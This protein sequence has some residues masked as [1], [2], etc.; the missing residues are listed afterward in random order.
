MNRRSVKPAVTGDAR[1]QRAQLREKL[2]YAAHRTLEALWAMRG[3]DG[4]VTV[5]IDKLATAR[6]FAA[7]TPRQV[8][9]AL[10]RLRRAGLV[11]D[12]GVDKDPARRRRHLRRRRVYGAPVAGVL[13]AES[14]VLVP[15]ATARWLA[16]ACAHGG[17][18]RGAGRPPREGR[19]KL[20]ASFSSG[21]VEAP[22]APDSSAS[23]RG[24]S[25]GNDSEKP[26][27]P[28]QGNV[29]IKLAAS[30]S[31]SWAKTHTCG[32]LHISMIW[33]HPS[34]LHPGKNPG[35]GRAGA[36]GS[37]SLL[38]SERGGAGCAEAL[39]ALGGPQAAPADPG[40]ASVGPDDLR[41]QGGPAAAPPDRGMFDPIRG[42][43]GNPWQTAG[44]VTVPGPP[45]LPAEASD[46]EC[47]HALVRA[48]G[49]AV[50]A[51]L[52]LKVFTGRPMTPKRKEW[53]ML[54]TAAA[55][56]REANAAPAAWAA[57]SCDVWKEYGNGGAPPLQWVFSPKR[58]DERRG[59]FEAE[60][61]GYGGGT[62]VNG[63]AKRALLARYL[64]ARTAIMRA[65]G[66]DP[67]AVFDRVFP[68]AEYER[69]V[70]AAKREN[71]LLTKELRAMVDR[72][73]FVWFTAPGKLVDA[74]C[75]KAWG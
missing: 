55:K 23:L 65:R 72:G 18:R 62:I 35:D 8:R 42:V 30:A 1:A 58:L 73:E 46:G 74:I 70:T 41:P 14:L 64:Q 9:A 50:G 13:C 27:V 48:Y 38:G 57:W 60:A 54:V 7:L 22:P 75:G 67:R 31:T 34:D 43:P 25:A 5:A 49:G 16:T 71:A 44:M 15:A 17:A 37:G 32:G 63:P 3:H 45:R 28:A 29:E 61:G 36:S 56:L 12:L 53:R 66:A 52:R 40:A 47:V 21:P 51:V 69:A 11:R 59:W 4:C 6:G 24:A 39:L 2:G 19:I 20:A 68:P 10:A 26:A 33:D